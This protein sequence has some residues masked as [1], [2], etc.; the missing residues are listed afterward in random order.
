[1]RNLRNTRFDKSQPPAQFHGRPLTSIT[2][3]LADSDDT[4]I[5]TFGPT[6]EDVVIEL[7]RIRT[8]SGRL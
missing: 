3:D 2:W 7:V 6:I 5:C 1:M 4:L 8:N